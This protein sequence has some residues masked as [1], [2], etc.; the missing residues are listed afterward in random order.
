M[1]CYRDMTF[2][3]FWQECIRGHNC[4]RA[5]TKTVEHRAALAK[6]EICRW[7]EK[8]ECFKEIGSRSDVNSGNNQISNT[9][10]HDNMSDVT[11]QNEG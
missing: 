8:P 10:T 1:M 3:P 6:L 4:E 7:T 2:C 11:V 5:L 9:K